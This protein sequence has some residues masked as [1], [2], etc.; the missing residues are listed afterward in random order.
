MKGTNN[1]L[2]NSVVAKCGWYTIFDIV[3]SDIE[4]VLT[5]CV[6]GTAAPTSINYKDVV[7]N[8]SDNLYNVSSQARMK[9]G[10][11]LKYRCKNG[12]DLQ[13]DTNLRE[14]AQDQVKVYCEDGLF[15]YPDSWPICVNNI[16]CTDPGSTTELTRTENKLSN[17]TYTSELKYV[18]NDVRS[19]VKIKNSNDLPT[20]NIVSTCKWRKTYDVDGKNLQCVIH[21]CGHPNIG[22]GSHPLPPVENYLNLVPTANITASFVSFGTNIVYKCDSS[23]YI[24]NTEIDPTQ[25]EINVKCLTS[26]IYEI[27]I[28][29]PN[30]TK[31]VSC[32]TPPLK[33]ENGT[34]TWLVQGTQNQVHFSFLF[35]G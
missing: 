11:F 24:E 18:C 20:Q 8:N 21:H 19:F 29:W 31:T 22:N 9:I 6:N 12:F 1:S 34:I 4:C 10:D 30:C 17:F 26:G 14:E 27:P 13:N 28:K 25:T 16:Q 2:S 3:P 23:K 33:P 5:Y 35:V 7:E 32:G 15:K